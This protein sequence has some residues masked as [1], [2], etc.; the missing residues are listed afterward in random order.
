MMLFCDAH[1]I[2]SGAQPKID[3]ESRLV[4]EI[5]EFYL[6]LANGKKAEK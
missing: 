1:V 3:D 5:R 6:F 2:V 4:N